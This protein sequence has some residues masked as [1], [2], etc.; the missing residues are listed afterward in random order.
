MLVHHTNTSKENCSKDVFFF[1]KLMGKFPFIKK[2]EEKDTSNSPGLSWPA[3]LSLSSCPSESNSPC[4]RHT[5]LV[6]SELLILLFSSKRFPLV[7]TR[8]S[9]Y[10]RKWRTWRQ[11]LTSKLTMKSEF[12][13]M[14]FFLPGRKQMCRITGREVSSFIM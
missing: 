5:V 1:F 2:K 13:Y 7:E 12:V 4:S 11:S 14:S 8:S 3:S 9:H 10:S 6:V